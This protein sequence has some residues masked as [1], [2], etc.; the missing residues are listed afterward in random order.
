MKKTVFIFSLFVIVGLLGVQQANAQSESVKEVVGWN[1]FVPCANNGVG[2]MVTGTIT[3]H[4]V[5]HT[6]KLGV[7]TK[8]HS[9][10]QSSAMVGAST[11]MTYKATGV[12]QTMTK[13][14]G[15]G[16][17]TRTFINRYHF[18]GKGIQF[19]IKNTSHLTI[20]PD[21]DVIV[22]FTKSSVECK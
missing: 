1:V 13:A 12:T 9:Q 5:I 18:V 4:T 14:P 16:A 3:M 17:F 11:G 7:I 19:Y 21:G 8:V 20:T 22:D 10:P 2:E 15:N 6:N